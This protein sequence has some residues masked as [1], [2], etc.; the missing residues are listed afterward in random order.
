MVV[1]LQIL[2]D[3]LQKIGSFTANIYSFSIIIYC[4]TAQ[5]DTPENVV[6][7]HDQIAHVPVLHRGL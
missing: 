1:S 2:L 3:S 7:V 6:N 5:I 4:F